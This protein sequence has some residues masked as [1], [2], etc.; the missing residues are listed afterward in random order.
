MAKWIKINGILDVEPKNGKDFSLE[1]L[2]Q[3]VGGYI[4]IVDLGKEC[5]V[6]NEEGKLHN[7]PINI[8]ATNIAHDA[9]A[10]FLGDYI[11]G[12]VLRCDRKQIK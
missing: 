4:Q 8:T 5:L 1:E 9:G 12:N 6:I 11:V 2:Q 7:L 10:L 3:Y